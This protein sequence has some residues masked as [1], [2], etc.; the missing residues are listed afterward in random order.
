MELH[1]DLADTQQK[2]KQHFHVLAV[3]DSLIERKLLERLLTESSCKVTCV[4]SGDKALEYLSLLDSQEIEYS[5]DLSSSPPSAQQEAGYMK[6]NLI[7]TDYSMPG[8]SGY[9]LLKRVK[10]QGSSWKDIPVVVM[11]SENV[12]SRINMCMEE[13]AEEFLLKPLQLS[14]LKKLQPH[15]LKS[16]V[17]PTE[18]ISTSNDHGSDNNVIHDI[19]LND[20]DNLVSERKVMSPEPLERRPKINGLLVV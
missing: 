13:G 5:T 10:M 9:D 11:S 8:M 17:H 4:D 6:V 2:Q 15:L 18:D 1:T 16:L 19:A 3:D 12:P 14:D 7:M 20:S